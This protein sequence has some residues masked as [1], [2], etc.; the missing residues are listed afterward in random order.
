M[1]Q[2]RAPNVTG[3]LE[4]DRPADGNGR[5]RCFSFKVIP[6]FSSFA[7]LIL[8]LFLLVSNFYSDLDLALKK[9]G[10]EM[11]MAT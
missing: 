4:R 6:G 5:A 11:T 1:P 3:Q 2:S 10:I 7:T 9:D 8:E